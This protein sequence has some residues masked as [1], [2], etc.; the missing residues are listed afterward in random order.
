MSERRVD[1]AVRQWADT[2]L[3]VTLQGRE[4]QAAGRVGLASLDFELPQRGT[5]YFFTT[6]RGNIEISARPINSHLLQQLTNFAWL[7]AL[8]VAALCGW[9]LVQKV[10]R[11]R[12]GQIVV[13]TLLCI[14]GPMLVVFGT[15]P[16]FGIVMIL[17]GVLLLLAAGQ[18][19]NCGPPAKRRRPEEGG[20]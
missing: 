4:Q 14:T 3:G 20:I 9:W 12:R 17:G 1:D 16:I 19:P 10:T 7:V 6:P 8:V 18:W 13:A 15:L 5:T 11:S 2:G